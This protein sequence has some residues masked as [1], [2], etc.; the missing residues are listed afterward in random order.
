M[1]GSKAEQDARDGTEDGAGHSRISVDSWPKGRETI[2]PLLQAA[3]GYA[4]VRGLFQHE[5]TCW[6]RACRITCTCT[7]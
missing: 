1:T 5:K 4:M 2:F 7:H 3:A 6:S